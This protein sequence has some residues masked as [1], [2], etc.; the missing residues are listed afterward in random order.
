M[1]EPAY[2][3]WWALHLRV[4]RGESLDAADRAAYEAGL[5]QLHREERL[6]HGAESL[7]RARATVQ[8]LEAEHTRLHGQRERLDA[9]IA[10]M[11]AMLDAGTREQLALKD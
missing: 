6:E 2:R 11:E 3:A 10:A 8:T 5:K 7:R 1:D 9:E 4:A